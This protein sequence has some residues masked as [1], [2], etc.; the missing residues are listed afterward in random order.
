M[1]CTALTADIRSEVLPPAWG[2]MMP[3]ISLL[4]TVSRALSTL[5]TL[6]YSGE[7]DPS[8]YEMFEKSRAR[9]GRQYLSGAFVAKRTVP[10]TF[11]PGANNSSPFLHAMNSPV[12]HSG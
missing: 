8:R 2:C 9:R 6:A 7:Y 5:K 10:L 4:R 11:V 12:L 1:G 3:R